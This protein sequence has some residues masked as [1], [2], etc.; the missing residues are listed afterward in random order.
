[1]L[2]MLL[3]R[4]GAYNRGGNEPHWRKQKD[5]WYLDGETPEAWQQRMNPTGT[6]EPRRE[7]TEIEGST[8]TAI[9][10]PPAKRDTR[11]ASGAARDLLGITEPQTDAELEAEWIIRQ[12]QQELARQ[13]AARRAREQ[14]DELAMV[15]MLMEM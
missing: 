2:A 12:H 10:E 9:E 4:V 7:P 14:E 13:E 5:D 6:D 8:A 3:Y 11:A 1:M 15:M